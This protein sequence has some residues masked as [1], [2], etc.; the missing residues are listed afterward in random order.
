MR[1]C[2][3]AG[4][5]AKPIHKARTR[6]S[7]EPGCGK[8]VGVAAILT[9]SPGNPVIGTKAGSVALVLGLDRLLV[10]H[11]RPHEMQGGIIR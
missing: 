6:L 11:E 5:G 2:Q 8:Y 9:E 10:V 7:L 1:I 4:A 3:V